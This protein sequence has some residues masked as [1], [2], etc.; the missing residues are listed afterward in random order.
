[1]GR[2]LVFCFGCCCLQKNLALRMKCLSTIKTLIFIVNSTQMP[3]DIVQNGTFK[4][5]MKSMQFPI[6]RNAQNVKQITKKYYE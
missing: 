2:K 6:Q 5:I 3:N 4:L 1:M